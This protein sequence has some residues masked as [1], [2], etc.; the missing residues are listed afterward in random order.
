MTT[1]ILPG[2][3]GSGPAHWQRWWLGQDRD[4]RLV[5]QHDWER[6]ELGA[7]LNTAALALEAWPGAI[8]VAHSLACALVAH[9]ADTRPDL[10]IGGALLVAPAD[11]DD[12]LRT[13]IEAESFAPLPLER[14]PFPAIVVGSSNDPY[15]SI[16]RAMLF[17]YSW[18]ARFV[19]LRDS[20]HINAESGFG[21]WTDG[22]RLAKRLRD[23]PERRTPRLRVVPPAYPE[24]AVRNAMPV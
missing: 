21:P 15:V 19:H 6:P 16:G 18:G 17:A 24:R 1:L 13:P 3:N 7:W 12:R 14:L 4:A 20:G 8:L 5:E 23:A 9:L 10:S 2:L 22:L 11:V